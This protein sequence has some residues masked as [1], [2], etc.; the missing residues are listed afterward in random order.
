[1]AKKFVKPRVGD[2]FAIPLPDGDQ[3][4]GQVVSDIQELGAVGCAFF[5][6]KVRP[7]DR[8][9]DLGNPISVLLTTQ[10]LLQRRYWPVLESRP[11]GVPEA[12]FAWEDFRDKLWV[13]TVIRGSGIVREF[14]EAYHGFIPW[15]T[16]ADPDYF[17]K[18][19]IE[20]EVKP[21]S[22][23]VARP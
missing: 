17:T 13:G 12:H 16:M 10:D 11:V 22:A 7:E 5:A 15:N 18:L 8:V 4:I 9:P 14:M 21:A 20:G 23:Y 6:L 3:A 2:V 1:L 19:L